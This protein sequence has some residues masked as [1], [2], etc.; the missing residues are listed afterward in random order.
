LGSQ[1]C[2]VDP[3]A[4][5]QLFTFGVKIGAP[6]TTVYTTEFIS[7]GGASAGERRF[8]IGPTMEVRLPFQLSEVDALWRQSSFT[9]IGANINYL[10]SSVNDWQIPL[11]GKYER[12]SGPIHPFIDGGVVYRHVSTD[13]SLP[14]TNPS[15]AGVTAGGGMLKL[16]RLRLSPE[17]RYTKWPTPAFSS[18]YAGPVI[19]KSNQVDLLVGITF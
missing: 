5:S 3:P 14:P 12:K 2:Q 7:N 1:S 10:H 11:M 13:S 6:L 15:T 16:W 17:L 19:G 8:T 18:A 9:E 4:Y